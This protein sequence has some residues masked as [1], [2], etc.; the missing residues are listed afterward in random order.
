[1]SKDEYIRKERG[2]QWGGN[3][4]TCLRNEWTGEW[5]EGVW[6]KNYNNTCK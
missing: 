2:M 1:M 6:E 3:R 4:W 5:I